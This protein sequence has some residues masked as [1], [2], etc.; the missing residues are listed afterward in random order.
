MFVR[1]SIIRKDIF[2]SVAVPLTGGV[3][4]FY[5][6]FLKYRV[7]SVT[8]KTFNGLGWVHMGDIGN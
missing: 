6:W 4:Q 3:K 8:T 7:Y 5:S 2:G 1:S